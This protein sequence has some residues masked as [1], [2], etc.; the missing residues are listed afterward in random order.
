MGLSKVG[1]DALPGWG[2]DSAAQAL[3]PFVASCAHLDESLGGIGV[4]AQL[5]GSAKNW[6]PACNAARLIPK[7]DEARARAFFETH[8]QPYA[9]TADGRDKGLFT[10]YYEPEVRGSRSPGPGY[11]SAL[12][13]RPRDLVQVD[14]T[15]FSP[16]LK[17]RRIGGRISSGTLVPYY[18]RA[19]IAA[20][21]LKGRRLELIWL[22]SDVDAFFLQ[23][24]GSGRIRLPD[25][26]VARVTYSAQNDRPYVPIG[27]VLADRGAIPLDQ[28]SMQSIRA[29]LESHPGEAQGVMNQ[30]PSFVFFREVIGTKPDEGPPGALG[31]A[32]S[33]G[34]S[35]AVDRAYLP[36]GAPVF[37]DT[38]D[39]ISGAPLQRMMVAQDLGGAI[40][41]PVRADIF[42]GWGP[43]AENHAGR[44]RQQGRQFLLLPKAAPAG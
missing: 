5:G 29:W 9:V 41:G 10:G 30:N 26:K 11:R 17:G 1:F 43:D 19:D 36:L 8:F 37:I 24:Q 40:K 3:A 13:S 2:Q 22:A 16:D 6:R 38:T 21:A 31:A 42:F 4:A 15:A 33:P 18:D 23:I 20:G 32:L 27:K 44:M 14:L 25:G 12:L 7:G 28:V 34:R 35:I 39:P